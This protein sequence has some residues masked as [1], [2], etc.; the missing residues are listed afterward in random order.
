MSWRVLRSRPCS[1]PKG[2]GCGYARSLLRNFPLVI[3]GWNVLEVMLVL[4]GRNR[5]GDR[6]AKTTVTEE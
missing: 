3:P 1:P 6:L 2:E 5:T 4:L